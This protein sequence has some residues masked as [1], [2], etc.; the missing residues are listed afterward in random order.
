MV[1]R[2][3]RVR[4]GVVGWR[5]AV[6]LLAG[7]VVAGGGTAGATDITVTYGPPGGV[8]TI[9]SVVQQAN[10]DVLVSWTMPAGHTPTNLHWDTSNAT[11]D[12][13][14]PNEGGAMTCMTTGPADGK[15]SCVGGRDQG[16]SNTT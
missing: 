4:P 3:G 2:R 13:G 14:A 16:T 15:H 1:A 12:I 10:G 5:L 6:A 9:D 7:A 8:P 11:T